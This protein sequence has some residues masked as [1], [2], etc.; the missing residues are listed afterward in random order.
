M[1]L[2]ILFFI[3]EL[4]YSYIPSDAIKYVKK[5]NG[6][7]NPSYNSYKGSKE[8]QYTNFVSQALFAAGESFS[9][10]K[11]KDRYGMI[12][13]YND[14]IYCLGLKGWKNTTK[15]IPAVK[16]GYP[17]SLK[18]DRVPMISIGF[19]GNKTNYCGY[20]DENKC[21]EMDNSDLIFFYK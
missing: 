5:W 10:C 1:K 11:G 4:I 8:N 2:F 19:E 13:R 9:G 16:A 3:L 21:S 17:I 15:K 20:D 12:Y 14:L 6:T 7:F 18:G